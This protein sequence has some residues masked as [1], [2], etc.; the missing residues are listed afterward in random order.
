MMYFKKLDERQKVIVYKC[1]FE[2]FILLMFM[3]C[4]ELILPVFK[5]NLF[6][7]Q[8]GLIIML[9]IS[10]WYFNIRKA[11]FDC[12][13][14]DEKRRRNRIVMT[15]TTIFLTIYSADMFY[16]DI[17]HDGISF[18]NADGLLNYYLLGLI[19]L[20]SFWIITGIKWYQKKQGFEEDN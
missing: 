11:W 17:L 10:L 8:I 16:Y 14:S 12:E 4:I 18:V 1:G 6:N 13:V 3:V 5:V 2:S 19:I 9:Y 7:G 15:A 20:I